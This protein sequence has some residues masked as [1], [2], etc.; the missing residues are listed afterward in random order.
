MNAQGHWTQVWDFGTVESLT[1]FY[2]A[3]PGSAL[4]R[5]ADQLFETAPSKVSPTLWGAPLPGRFA[6]ALRQRQDAFAADMAGRILDTGELDFAAFYLERAEDLG[7]ALMLA[8]HLRRRKADLRV[9]GAGPWL[10]VFAE[11]DEKITGTVFALPDLNQPLRGS[12]PDRGILLDIGVRKPFR[13]RG[14]NL[15]M[16]A[17][18]YLGM[19]E[20]GYQDAS[21]TI[22]LDENSASRRTAEKLGGR[23]ARNFV[24]YR[25]ELI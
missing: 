19:I 15:A 2:P 14:I 13:G 7:A 25:R 21:Y 11:I 24:V 5:M 9:F 17:K 10:T 16:A 1:R 18:S 4:L 22:V 6:R 20:R 23:V 8:G 12:Q 3:H